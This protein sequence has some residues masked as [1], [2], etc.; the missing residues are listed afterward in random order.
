MKKITAIALVVVSLC[1]VGCSDNKPA[2]KPT[3]GAAPAPT[4]AA[5]K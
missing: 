1:I 2:A 3:G 4:G 5:G